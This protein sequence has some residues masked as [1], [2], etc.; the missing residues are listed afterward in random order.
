MNSL[1]NL[2]N[3]K[4]KL[5][6]LKLEKENIQKILRSQIHVANSGKINIAKLKLRSELVNQEIKK[7]EGDS[8]PN[9][10]A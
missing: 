5:K 9:I 10:I 2:C 1:K 6:A 7:I 4:F 3:P 8:I